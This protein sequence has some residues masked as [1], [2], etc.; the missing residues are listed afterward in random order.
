MMKRNI[1]EKSL[2]LKNNKFY[3]NLIIQNKIK[4]MFKNKNKMN[5]KMIMKKKMIMIMMMKMNK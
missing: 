2:K 3:A 5:M 1:Q 4:T